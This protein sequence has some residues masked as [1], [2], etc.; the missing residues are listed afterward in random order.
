MNAEQEIWDFLHRHLQSIF[1]R[2]VE[3]YRTTTGSD[4]SLYEW[5]VAPHRQDGLDFHYFMIEHGWA[6]GRQ[7]AVRSA[8]AT[9]AAERGTPLSPATP[10]CSRWPEMT[11]SAT[12]PQREPRAGAARRR[13]SRSSMSTSRRRG[14]RRA[15]SPDNQRPGSG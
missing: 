8:G 3:T 14:K 10:S 12:R 9:A 13:V 6:G 7:P 15:S 4:L 1:T 2:D 5:F 11:A